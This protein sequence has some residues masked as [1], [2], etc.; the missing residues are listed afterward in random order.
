MFEY[1][2]APDYL[3][4]EPEEVRARVRL[5]MRLMEESLAEEEMSDEEVLT[6]SFNS[7][8]QSEHERKEI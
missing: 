4:C 6:A 7:L 1:A 8:S 5:A 2:D 3:A